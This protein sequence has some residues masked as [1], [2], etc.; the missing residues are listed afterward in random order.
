MGLGLATRLNLGALRCANAPYTVHIG[1]TRVGRNS[2]PSPGCQSGATLTERTNPKPGTNL[3]NDAQFTPH[4][5]GTH[6]MNHP[7]HGFTLIELMIVM[8]II[9]IIA[10]I[11]LPAYQ[12]YAGKAQVSTGLAEIHPGI[13]TYEL[14]VLEGKVL[15]TDY[16]ATNLGLKASTARCSTIAVTKIANDGKAEPAISCTLI[17][18]SKV[19]G[20]VVRYDRTANGTWNC[21]SSAP[22]EFYRPQGCSAL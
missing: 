7:H 17:G 19:H 3:A 21:K 22:S 8:V 11:A 4:A 10:A 20:K 14:L 5:Q 18:N 2:N 12:D 15:E 1:V 13:K 9:G 16:T 6:T